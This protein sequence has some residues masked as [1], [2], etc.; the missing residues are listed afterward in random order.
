MREGVFGK[1]I[2]TCMCHPHV[3][4]NRDDKAAFRFLLVET[5]EHNIVFVGHLMK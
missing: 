1:P 2:N 5:A 4:Q 3:Q